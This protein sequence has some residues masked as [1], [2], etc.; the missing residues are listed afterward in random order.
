MAFIG[1]GVM[2]GGLV[3]SVADEG[4]FALVIP[5]FVALFIGLAI[6]TNGLM[7]TVPRKKFPDHSPDLLGQKS[8]D[9]GTK[10][11]G[12]QST[13]LVP[14]APTN[15]LNA[16]ERASLSVTEPTTHQLKTGR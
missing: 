1:L 5:G 3:A 11:S 9:S 12:F 15:D 8:L 13:A 6:I 4:F 2:L 16:G 7:F 10:A 14:D